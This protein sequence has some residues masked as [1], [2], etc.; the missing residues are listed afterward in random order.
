MKRQPEW[1]NIFIDET[2]DKGL[3]PKIYEELTK[4]SKKNTNN[5][6]LK[7]GKGPE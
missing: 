6:Q 1:G 4:L 5:P 7:I 2:N 3:I